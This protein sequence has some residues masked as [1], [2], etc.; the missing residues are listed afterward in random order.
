[1]GGG[2]LV[3]EPVWTISEEIRRGVNVV[4]VLL[5]CYA[6]LIVVIYRRFETAYRARIARIQYTV[7][8]IIITV[9]FVFV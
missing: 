6:A 4:F 9:A 2:G 5:G 7:V 1:M 8:V 3:P